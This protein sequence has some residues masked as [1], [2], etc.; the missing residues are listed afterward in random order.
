MPA[1]RWYGGTSFTRSPPM[2]IPPPSGQKKPAMRL[3][4]VV[5]PHPDGPSRVMTSPRLIANDM[6]CSAT[7][8]PNRLLTR[9]KHTASSPPM[10][11][12]LDIEDLV[13]AEERIGEREQGRGGDD[14]DHRQCGHRGIGI[15]AHVIVHHD[16]QGLGPLRGD[17][18]RRGEFVERQD[19]GKQPAADE[20]RQQ[21]RQRDGGQDA[22]RRRTKT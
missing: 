6:S 17:K 3:S 10:S 18:Q 11:V 15:F 14:V 1:S 13:E 2:R 4:T 20:T 19:G 16:R 7:T 8:V 21:Q 9:S 5:F 12:L 22:Q